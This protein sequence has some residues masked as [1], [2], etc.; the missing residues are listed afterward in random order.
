MTNP[1]LV[2]KILSLAIK[3]KGLITQ[4]DTAL[5]FYNLSAIKQKIGELQ[6]YFPKKTLHTAAVKANPLFNIL[7]F[8]KQQGIGAET[9]SLPELYL[10]QKSGF[11]PKNIVFDSPIKTNEEL[12]YALKANI[13]IN[14]DS[15]IELRELLN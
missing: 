6:K 11:D 2:S 10:A 8:V 5:I 4:S 15:F 3:R 9:A 7:K 1:K 12:E 13:H 14:A